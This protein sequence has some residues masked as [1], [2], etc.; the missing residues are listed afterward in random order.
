MLESTCHKLSCTVK[1]QIR[2]IC[3]YIGCTKV[4]T[5]NWDIMSLITIKYLFANIS[6]ITR[7]I[8]II[9]LVLES[10]YQTVLII[11]GISHSNKYL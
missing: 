11:Y 9:K 2:A 3:T 8:Y 1:S 7:W 4:T 5:N 10:A 6:R